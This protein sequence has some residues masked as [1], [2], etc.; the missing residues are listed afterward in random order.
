MP[1]STFTAFVLQAFLP[2]EIGFFVKAGA[3]LE[4]HRHVLA[5]AYGI[6]EGVD[7]LA[8]GGEAIAGDL[9]GGDVGSI[10]ASRSIS[11]TGLNE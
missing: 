5:V 6:Y 4:H 2:F 3:Q 8:I 1:I 9:D 11:I 10:A 7:D